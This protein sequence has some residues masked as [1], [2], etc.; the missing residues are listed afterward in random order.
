[1]RL[2]IL[3]AILLTGVLLLL[4]RPGMAGQETAEQER[5]TLIDDVGA[6]KR[7]LLVLLSMGLGRAGMWEEASVI[8]QHLVDTA[9]D[10]LESCLAQ[11]AVVWQMTEAGPYL[12]ATYNEWEKLRGTVDR[13]GADTRFTPEEAAACRAGYR[14]VTGNLIYGGMLTSDLG[15]ASL[16]KIRVVFAAYFGAAQPGV[17][18]DGVSRRR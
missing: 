18:A 4:A 12:D 10:P 7:A 3:A 5:S 6:L 14:R 16:E 2:R 13:I 9:D 8:S 15:R 17:E 1:M 11:A